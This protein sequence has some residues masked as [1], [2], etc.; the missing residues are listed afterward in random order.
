MTLKELKK[1]VKELVSKAK[2]EQ[3]LTEISKWARQHNN[4]DLI[5]QT[6]NLS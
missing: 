6:S 3:A 4:E 2:T 1:K 5:N